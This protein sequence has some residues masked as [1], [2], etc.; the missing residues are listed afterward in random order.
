MKKNNILFKHWDS[1]P[2]EVILSI[3][4]LVVIVALFYFSMWGA[5][6]LGLLDN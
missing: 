3:V 6:I 5:H 2:K 1:D 4:F